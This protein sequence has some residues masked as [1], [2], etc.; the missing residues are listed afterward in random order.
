M[1]ILGLPLEFAGVEALPSASPPSGLRPRR[2]SLL[3]LPATVTMRAAAAGLL[4]PSPA[5]RRLPPPRPSAP[6]ARPAARLHRRLV[7]ARLPCCRRRPRREERRGEL[8]Q[9]AEERRGKNGEEC[10]K[11]QREKKE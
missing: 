6:L 7:P 10:R 3:A 5:C 11:E 9:S 8:R 1:D 4:R 2:C